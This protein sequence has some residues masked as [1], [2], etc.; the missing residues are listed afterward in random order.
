MVACAKLPAAASEG[1]VS[2]HATDRYLRTVV[3]CPRQRNVRCREGG[4]CGGT[5]NMG[6]FETF[7]GDVACPRT[8]ALPDDRFGRLTW[9][10]ERI[11]LRLNSAPFETRVPFETQQSRTSYRGFAGFRTNFASNRQLL[12][13]EGV[14]ETWT[15]TRVKKAR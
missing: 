14:W 3:A 8:A 12:R 6:A 4:R 2:I 11:F 10:E 1:D 13:D 7:G 5:I 15:R 9:A